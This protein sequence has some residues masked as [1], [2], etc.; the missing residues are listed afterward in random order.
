MQKHPYQKLEMSLLSGLPNEVDFAVNVCTLLSNEGRHSLNIN[1]CPQL[2]DILMG[3]VGVFKDG[4]G[5]LAVLYKEGF[6]ANT[7][8]NFPRVSDLAL[9]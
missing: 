4:A 3:H 5:S 1:R 8:R 7:G 2:V 6:Q 9:E